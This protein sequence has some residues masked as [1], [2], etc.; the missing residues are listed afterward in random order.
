MVYL[1]L[2][3]AVIAVILGGLGTKAYYDIDHNPDED[4][5]VGDITV[6]GVL[7]AHNDVVLNDTVHINDGTRHGNYGE[8][9]VTGTTKLHTVGTRMILPDGRV[10][11]YAL[12]NGAL[13]AGQ[14]VQESANVALHDMDLAVATAAIGA[15]QITVTPG[16]TAVTANQ[17]QGGYLYV[18]DGAGG[19]GQVYAIA[20][21]PAADASTAFV[22]T[23]QSGITQ[24]FTN[25]TTLV[26]LKANAYFDCIPAPVVPTARILG[27]PVADIA[28]NGYGW[29]QTWGEAAL[30]VDTLVPVVGEDLYPSSNTSGA[31]DNVVG[32]DIISGTRVKGASIEAQDFADAAVTSGDVIVSQ[33]GTGAA[34]ISGITAAVTAIEAETATTLVY[35]FLTADLAYLP[36]VG[37]ILSISVSGLESASSVATASGSVNVTTVVTGVANG[38]LNGGL[39]NASNYHIQLGQSLCQNTLGAEID[40]ADDFTI[41][42]IRM[43]KPASQSIG[44][45]LSIPAVDT[46]YQLSYLQIAP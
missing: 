38:A 14:L 19:E 40:G 23:L 21:H 2:F 25:G 43:V 27:A 4:H 20:S 9:H 28:D 8:E 6:N 10:F 13:P 22:V 26:G 31:V 44:T 24:A 42:S 17:Y 11:R 33:G 32:V 16:A 41:N 37:D 5:E 35:S 15:T 46:D 1:A 7:T 29:V 34:D 36:R 18:N 39:T 30:L 3:L 45:A 12:A